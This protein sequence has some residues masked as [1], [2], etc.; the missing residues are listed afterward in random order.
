MRPQ[1]MAAASRSMAICRFS[2]FE[3]VRPVE[4]DEGDGTATFDF[5]GRGGHERVLDLIRPA[6]W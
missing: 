4:R 3:D 6:R 2:V 5:D 1:V